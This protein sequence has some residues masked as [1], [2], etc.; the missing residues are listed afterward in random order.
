MFETGEIAGTYESIRPDD[1]WSITL[2]ENGTLE[3][4]LNS[5]KHGEYLWEIAGQEIHVEAN[6]SRGRIYRINDDDSLTSIAYRD[7]GK[8]IHRPEDKQAI[9]KRIT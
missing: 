1:T 2:L 4:Y 9:Y 7:E 8:R 3:T 6:G 5:E